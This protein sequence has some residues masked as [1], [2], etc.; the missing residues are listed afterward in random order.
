MLVTIRDI[1]SLKSYGANLQLI[2]GYWM[3]KRGSRPMP[4]RSDLDPTEIPPRLLPGLSHVFE[5]LEEIAV[6]PSSLLEL[7][8]QGSLWVGVGSNDVE[9]KALENGKVCRCVVLAV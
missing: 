6:I 1:E 9:G 3:R 8:P 5:H 7:G 4:Q 2:Y